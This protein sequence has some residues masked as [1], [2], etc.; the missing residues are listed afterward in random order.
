MTRNFQLYHSSQV[1]RKSFCRDIKQG[2]KSLK[3]KYL[4]LVAVLAL[5]SP[6][7]R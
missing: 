5:G 7:N 1:E 6:K 2:I 4:E 3:Y